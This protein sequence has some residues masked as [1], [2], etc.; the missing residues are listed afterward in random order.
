MNAPFRVIE[1]A[2]KDR[3][4]LKRSYLKDRPH[5]GLVV[6]TTSPVQVDDVVDLKIWLRREDLYLVIRGTV[7]WVRSKELRAKELGIGFFKH[8]SEKR[9]ML[10]RHTKVLGRESQTRQDSRLNA[11]IKV[12]YKTPL[13]YAI[14]TTK[15][16]SSGGMF[17]YSTR[18]PP[19]NSIIV[20]K[21]CPPGEN[22]PIEL[23]GRVTW[24]CPGQGIG[25]RFM[26]NNPQ[27]R[28]RLD[29]LV[30]NTLPATPVFQE[31]AA[32]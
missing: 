16:L 3:E 20:F 7:L 11:T 27:A 13:D 14:D 8:E 28:N 21:L 4:T 26:G 1:A 17:I 2:F 12:M 22:Q 9:E 29:Q 15:N 19:L 30:E 31:A 6:S 23:M 18:L 25:V 32:G 5:G 10:L 24:R